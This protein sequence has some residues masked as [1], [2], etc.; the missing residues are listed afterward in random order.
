MV[1]NIGNNI[2][3]FCYNIGNKKGALS[4]FR[5]YLVIYI[6]PPFQQIHPD[7]DMPSLI[8]IS[9]TRSPQVNAAIR[10][11]ITKNYLSNN[12]P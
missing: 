7:C 2:Y 3:D 10:I 12:L 8:R 1:N 11:L 6:D 9:R 4:A 5:E